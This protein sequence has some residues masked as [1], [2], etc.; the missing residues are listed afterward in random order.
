MSKSK[1]MLQEYSTNCLASSIQKRLILKHLRSV[2]FVRLC[3]RL[4]LLLID[5][6]E[7][8]VDIVRE[9]QSQM[10]RIYKYKIGLERPRGQII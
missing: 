10:E 4:L 5:R 8:R 1:N 7:S 6:M 2:S 9:T 3:L